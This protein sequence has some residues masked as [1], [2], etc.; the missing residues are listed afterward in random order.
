M[1]AGEECISKN[2]FSHRWLRRNKEN[3]LQH[4]IFLA[5]GREGEPANEHID[6]PAPQNNSKC[7]LQLLIGI[8]QQV[9]GME[10][11]VILS[12]SLG[13]LVNRKRI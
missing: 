5:D 12:L 4:L 2:I 6:F 10:G 3:R 11:A 9:W 7:F 8:P 1:R 13:G